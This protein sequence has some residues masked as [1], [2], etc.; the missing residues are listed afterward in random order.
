MGSTT[1]T[2]S[3][4]P[5]IFADETARTQ[6]E[7]HG[8]VVTFRTTARTTGDTWWRKSRLGSKE[9]DVHVEALETVD[10]REPSELRPHRPVSGFET[11]EAWQQAIR[12]LNG[13][14]PAEGRLY[15]VS[16]RES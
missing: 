5:I 16:T 14:L 4:G 8:E 6:L 3:V 7:T 9:G 2:G 15:R 1:S 13:S 12:S 11:V 10:P